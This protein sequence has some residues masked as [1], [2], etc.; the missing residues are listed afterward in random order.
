MLQN[1]D[2]RKRDRTITPLNFHALSDETKI[3]RHS[4]PTS[5][6]E[7]TYLPNT[8]KTR[9]NWIWAVILELTLLFRKI[10]QLSQREPI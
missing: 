10:S 9:S 5:Q 8:K 6:D 4:Q 3:L 7:I 2:K 1:E